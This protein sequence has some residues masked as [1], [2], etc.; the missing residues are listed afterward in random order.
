M[1]IGTWEPGN[2]KDIDVVSHEKLIELLACFRDA[3]PEKLVDA[4]SSAQVRDN[5]GL[6]RL[7]A[8]SW[9]N[10]ELL[11][12]DELDALVRFFT[13]AEMQ[14]SGWDAGVRS[15]VVY[16]VREMKK[17]ES[18]TSELRKWIKKNTDN[19]YLPNGSAL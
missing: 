2:K 17:R 14:L 11:A 7:E 8:T 1:T 6:M 13:L 19:R 3:N 12:N 16:L 5:A 18:F 9:R 10:A 15:P 4:M